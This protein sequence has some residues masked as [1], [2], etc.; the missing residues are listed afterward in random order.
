MILLN[1]NLIFIYGK[2][3]T[4]NHPWA[5]S[6]LWSISFSCTTFL[7]FGGAN[8]CFTFCVSVTNVSSNFLTELKISS[9]YIWTHQ[10]IYW[11]CYFPR[12]LSP[13]ALSLPAPVWV[14]CSLVGCIAIILWLLCQHSRLCSS[15]M[16]ESSFLDF[17][18]SSFLVHSFNVLKHILQEPR[19]KWIHV[20]QNFR[21]S[22]LASL[23][24]P[25]VYPH[26]LIIFG[27]V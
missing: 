20:R 27:W 16:L 12:I 25:L 5:S 8:S 17:I 19:K 4:V 11:F 3:V 26:H 1:N 10:V 21:K 23:K 22:D 6:I 15:H 2:Y 9:Q 24:M 7:V 14:G 13:G 18:F